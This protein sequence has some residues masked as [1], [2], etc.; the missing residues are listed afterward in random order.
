[1]RFPQPA[2]R[3]PSRPRLALIPNASGLHRLLLQAGSLRGANKP[4]S[5]EDAAP[6]IRPLNN[7]HAPLICFGN[8]EARKAMLL[9]SREGGGAVDQVPPPAAI[10]LEAEGRTK[11]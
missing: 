8:V 6:V 3:R 9:D 11:R 1:M 7:E 10:H 5:A 2:G 4:E